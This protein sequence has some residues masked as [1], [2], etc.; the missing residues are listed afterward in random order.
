MINIK[1]KRLTDT[2]TLPRKAH[3]DDA[4][5][6]IY[7]DCPNNTFYEWDMQG[8]IN[9]V[10]GIKI[11]PGCAKVVTTGFATNIPNG[12]FVAVFPRSGMGIKRH[13]RL[14]NSTGIIDSGYVGEWLI[15]IY[16][17]GNETQIIKHGDRIAQF[18][19]LPVLDVN[20]TE[21]NE[22]DATGRGTNGFGSSGT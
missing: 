12:Y 3:H 1:I 6:D 13:L 8:N 17:D 21:V 20:L 15:S 10:R 5:F 9:S 14:S 18:A 11:E 7:A 4:C 16:N 19:I 2:A 22:L